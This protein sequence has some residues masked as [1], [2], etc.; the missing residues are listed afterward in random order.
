[1]AL[2][3][4]SHDPAI[5]PHCPWGG[6]ELI[7]LRLPSLLHARCFV[8][9]QDEE[10]EQV[11]QGLRGPGQARV[12]V[13]AGGVWGCGAGQSGRVQ[14][15]PLAMGALGRWVLGR[16]APGTA[17]LAAGHGWGSGR[18]RPRLQGAAARLNR[19]QGIIIIQAGKGG[20]GSGRVTFGS[21][22]ET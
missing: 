3:C 8:M 6:N 1:M 22:Q 19:L 12:S 17:V 2:G 13:G 21:D 4:S 7:L 18:L 15:P 9:R 10:W 20:L 14:P 11:I 16:P 5:V